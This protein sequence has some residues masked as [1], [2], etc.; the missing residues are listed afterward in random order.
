MWCSSALSDILMGIWHLFGISSPRKFWNKTYTT[1]FHLKNLANLHPMA[2][3]FRQSNLQCTVILQAG[4]FLSLP[5]RISVEK[6]YIPRKLYK[7]VGGIYFKKCWVGEKADLCQKDTVTILPHGH[8]LIGSNRSFNGGQLTGYLS[9]HCVLCR[10]FFPN[11]AKR[12]WQEWGD[13][14]PD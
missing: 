5:I 10:D 8:W 6:K 4:K 12:C 7:I 11:A 1:F 13:R 14:C 9:N 3:K 2:P